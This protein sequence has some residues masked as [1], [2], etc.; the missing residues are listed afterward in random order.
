MSQ[1]Q[2]TT[3]R[4]R[5]EKYENYYSEQYKTG[6]YIS[7]KAVLLGDEGVTPVDGAVS[8]FLSY[9]VQGKEL[10]LSVVINS[11]PLSE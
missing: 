10:F 2:Q 8:Y 7:N 6:V 11:T 1:K 9:K 5:E 3:D 4:F